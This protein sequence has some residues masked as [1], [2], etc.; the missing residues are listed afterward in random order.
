MAISSAGIGSNI[1]V[2]SLVSQ[3]LA[4]ERR[5]LDTLVQRKSL[6]NAELS[7][8]GKISSDL[9]SFQSAL[10]ALKEAD[11][12]KVFSA[13]ATDTDYLTA[14]A[15]ST[16]SAGNHD[17]TVTT[18]AKAQKLVSAT[19]VYA[20]TDTTT[21]GTGTLTISNGTDIFNVTIDG[22]NNTLNGVVEAINSGADNFG[23]TA[24]IINDGTGYR[25]ALSP[26]ETGTA[27]DITVAVTDTGDS[28]NTD[29]SG[30]SRLSYTAGAYNLTQTQAAVDAV[31]TVDGLAGIT[32]SSNT[33]SDVIQ[34]VT[35]NLKQQGVST[36]LNVTVDTAA[37]TTKVQDFAN[38][39]NKLV[40]DIKGYRQKGG[41]LEADNT[42]LTIQS[43]LHNVFNTPASLSG[44]SY[45][46]LAQVGVSIQASGTISVNTSD[47]QSAASSNLVDVVSLFTDSDEGFA[48]RLYSE[49]STLLQANGV[50][51]AK[52]DG[53]SSLISTTDTRI[54]QMEA[55]LTSTERRLRAQFSALD[56]LLGS[57]NATSS[58]LLR[59]LS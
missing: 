50:V 42:L 31:I 48:Q 15:D 21:L 26:T 17:I 22:S 23:V 58:L 37:L 52:T 16:A 12:F 55:R 10:S 32:K 34:G 53:I 36:T 43:Q 7:A 25:L 13:T 18:L 44:N 57:L 40:N 49:V 27:Y 6:Y 3:L 56:S 2:N 38:A 29:T 54:N 41:T 28:N 51:D 5:P 1:D 59:Q 14:T 47:F 33:I 4:I 30:L 45:S 19:P 9:S 20:D 46:Y 24:S 11:D 39:Y 35:L 8:F